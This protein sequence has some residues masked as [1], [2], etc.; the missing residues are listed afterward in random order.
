VHTFR[1]QNRGSNRVPVSDCLQAFIF[2][3]FREW[4]L[5]GHATAIICSCG[6][7]LLEPEFPPN[8]ADF[9]TGLG[10]VDQRRWPLVRRS[11]NRFDHWW[12]GGQSRNRRAWLFPGGVA[13]TP[14]IPTRNI[15]GE[16][17][18][19]PSGAASQPDRHA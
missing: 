1:C 5:R 8:S 3:W 6:A 10:L 16:I 17:C 12:S 2:Q 13:S 18:H 15:A 11:R 9:L 7:W 4:D 19:R 14:N